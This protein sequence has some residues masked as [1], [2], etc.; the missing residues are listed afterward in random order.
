MSSARDL[1]FGWFRSGAIPA[2]RLS[3]ALQHAGA[4]PVPRDWRRFVDLILLA[5]G[6]LLLLAGVVFFIAYNW[7]AIGRFGKF[8]LVQVLV[9]AALALVWRN[10]LESPG[11]KGALGA[12]VVLVGVLLAL[13]GQVYQTGADTFELFAAWAAL[14]LPWVVLGRMPVLWLF[15]L[16]LINTAVVLYHETFGRLLPILLGPLQLVWTLFLL[17]SAA[18]AV[19]E[20]VSECGGQHL[21]SRWPARCVATASGAAATGLAVYGVLDWQG[22]HVAGFLG[23][24][25]WLVLAYGYYRHRR[26]DVFV[27]AGGVLSVVV[28]VAAGLGRVAV[29][30][31]GEAA[32][33]LMVGLIVTGLG[34]IGGHWLKRVAAGQKT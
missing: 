30:G 9:L 10:G 16:L 33:L 26:I 7:Q 1:V 4:Y 8:A 13:I 14:V 23:W 24:L 19:W 20:F 5:L 11:G 31:T 18:L 25:G 15:W 3:D 27:L 21:G 6:V 2:E 22:A 28:V 34:A 12:A 17:N 32:S 29:D